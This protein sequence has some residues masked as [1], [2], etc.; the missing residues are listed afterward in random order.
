VGFSLTGF[1]DWDWEAEGYWCGVADRARPMSALH[2]WVPRAG[3]TPA[4]GAATVPERVIPVDFGYDGPVHLGE[5]MDYLAARLRLDDPAPGE[6]RGVRNG[7]PVAITAVL[8]SPVAEGEGAGLNI[9]PAVFQSA[10]RRWRALADAAVAKT[11]ARAEDRSMLVPLT[12][13]DAVP[14][15]LRLVP[16]GQRAAGTAEVGVRWRQRRRLVN[17]AAEPLANMAVAIPLGDTAALVAAGKALASGDDLR[18]WR[19]GRE[20]ARTLAGWGTADTR[21]WVL[22]PQL[23]PGAAIEWEVVYG[24]PQAG[25]GPVLSGPEA[26]AFDPAASSN[27]SLVYRTAPVAANAGKGAW[28]LDRGDAPPSPDFSRPGSWA[29]A[30]TLGR[31]ANRDDYAQARFSEYQDGGTRYLA[32]LDAVRARAGGLSP[33][34]NRAADGIVLRHPCG[35]TGITAGYRVL[36]Q[37]YIGPTSAPVGRVVLL[38]RGGAE[39]WRLVWEDFAVRDPEAVLVAG[40]VAVAPAARE[41][42]LAVWPANAVEVPRNAYAGRVCRARWETDTTVAVDA[43]K[44][45]FSVV[46]PEEAVNELATE[47]TVWADGR[48]RDARLLRVGGDRSRR[49]ALP[50]GRGVLLDAAARGA[51]LLAADG[52]AIAG[53]VPPAAVQAV[54]RITR[55]DGSVVEVAADAWPELA[56]RPNPLPNGSAFATAAGW[57]YGATDAG[58]VSNATLLVSAGRLRIGSI[59]TTGPNLGR[60]VR[61]DALLPLN[62]R[63]QVALALD[64]ETSNAG[65]YARPAIWWYDA[66]G[67]L[68]SRSTGDAYTTVAGA[69]VRRPLAARSPAGATHYRVGALVWAVATI[70]S[71]AN[72]YLDNVWPGGPEVGI[73]EAAAGT[74]EAQARWRPSYP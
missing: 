25:P 38:A 65:V 73:A 51:W 57:G 63:K 60:E 55:D 26:P 61:A 8:S 69:P 53:A 47:V 66:A 74:V 3:G 17:A 71:A 70:G 28:G 43:S 11:F 52:E 10:D 20:V 64:A 5:A 40:A 24:N 31:P 14:L 44:L 54:Q 13:V 37:R 62:G 42:A 36:N 68:V 4:L 41:I 16:T 45:V 7:V 46:Q 39:A 30:I 29:P 22:V 35:I 72:V 34:D 15:R 6:L 56:P 59:T 9:L 1:K 27:G 49:L 50:L 18:V 21:C 23:A 48:E 2:T 32:R 19:D 33:A 12:G 58:F 67:A